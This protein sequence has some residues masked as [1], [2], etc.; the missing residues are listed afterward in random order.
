LPGT[1]GI[2]VLR[3]V[4][5]GGQSLAAAWSSGSLI[6]LA[7]HSVALFT[8]GWVLFGFCERVAKQQGSLGQY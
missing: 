3:S 5:L 2:R 6:W 7:V 8:G 1:E 4:A